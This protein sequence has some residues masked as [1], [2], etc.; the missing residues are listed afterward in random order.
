VRPIVG[1]EHQP[2]AVGARRALSC[3]GHEL[4]SPL[5]VLMSS[6]ERVLDG[7]TDAPAAQLRAA[8]ERLRAISDVAREV[9]QTP[10]VA[11][12]MDLKVA[13]ESAA[14]RVCPALTID[15]PGDA[16]VRMTPRA[17][18]HVATAVV[19]AVARAAPDGAG[20][21]AHLEVGGGTVRLRVDPGA[22]P[23]AWQDIDPWTSE[24]HGL[25]LW[26]AALVAAESGGRVQVG[27]I[28]GAI[29][30][31]VELPEAP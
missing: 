4:A 27:E 23:I 14:S 24:R 3:I 21:R 17:A 13:V 31:I 16:P 15:A 2:E 7:R 22:V 20:V 9:V 19:R 10:G 30:V 18:G 12:R 25:D 1:S 6:L 28:D 8:A 11:Q 5:M 29:A 26:T